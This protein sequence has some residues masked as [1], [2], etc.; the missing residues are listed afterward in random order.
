MFHKL[1]ARIALALALAVPALSFAASPVN[2]NKA[3]ASTIAK[4]L[5]GIGQSKAD[6]IVA[7]RDA[8]GPFKSADDLAQVKGIGKATLERNRASILLADAAPGTA[9]AA[10]A[11]TD[12]PAKKVRRA[13]KKAAAAAVEE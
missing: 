11:R 5:D 9:A 13:S 2:I 1:A 12:A 8:N 7:W 6:A 3:D 10:V 4:S